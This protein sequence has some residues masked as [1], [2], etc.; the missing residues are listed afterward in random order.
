VIEENRIL[1]RK[2]AATR[3][4]LSEKTIDRICATDAGL[5]KIQISTRRVGISAADVTAY[6]EKATQAAA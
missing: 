3:L 4:G 2:E 6:L 1:S 5:R